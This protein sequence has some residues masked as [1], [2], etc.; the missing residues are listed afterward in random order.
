[1]CNGERY[2]LFLQAWASAAHPHALGVLHLHTVSA[3]IQLAAVYVVSALSDDSHRKTDWASQFHPAGGGAESLVDMKMDMSVSRRQRSVTTSSITGEPSSMFDVESSTRDL[4]CLDISPTPPPSFM[5]TPRAPPPEQRRA[6]PV[7]YLWHAWK[8]CKS[9]VTGS[10]VDEEKEAAGAAATAAVGTC[11]VLGHSHNRLAPASADGVFALEDSQQRGRRRRR[12]QAQKKLNRSDSGSGRGKGHWAC[13][14]SNW[15]RISL[16][17]VMG[18]LTFDLYLACLENRAGTPGAKKG[19]LFSS[20]PSSFYKEQEFRDPLFPDFPSSNDQFGP[21]SPH[22]VHVDD[23]HNGHTRRS[24]WDLGA[25]NGPPLTV[26]S[27][28]QTDAKEESQPIDNGVE[29]KPH[30]GKGAAA[31]DAGVRL[32]ERLPGHTAPEPP[33]H[34]PFGGQRVAVV[35]PYVGR[36]LP[37]WWDAF[38]EQA[39]LNDGLIDWIIFCDQVR[40][41][42]LC[43]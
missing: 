6:G 24:A 17:F 35:V 16:V 31:A 43:T 39:R 23:K 32:D 1:M 33:Q 11:P 25:K 42:P 38:A 28:P 13:L 8:R 4:S 3:E 9:Q 36:D 5:P 34:D 41:N 12:P 27:S 14:R 7:T 37:V 20:I 40:A 19:R 26:N 21:R 2:D 18:A 10:L 30:E 22:G 15:W 29:I